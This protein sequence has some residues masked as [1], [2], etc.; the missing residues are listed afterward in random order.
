MLA[1][2][3]FGR[4]GINYH[5]SEAQAERG[6]EKSIAVLDLEILLPR[7]QSDDKVGAYYGGSE[8]AC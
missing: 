6:R 7:K 5:Y 8:R 4:T 3:D 1:V 2:H